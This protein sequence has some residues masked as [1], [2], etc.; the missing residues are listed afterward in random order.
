MSAQPDSFAEMLEA[1]IRRYQNRTIEAAQVIAKL[2]ELAK[3]MRDWGAR[4]PRAQW[5]APPRSTGSLA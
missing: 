5:V 4:P 3:Q 2:I 1:T